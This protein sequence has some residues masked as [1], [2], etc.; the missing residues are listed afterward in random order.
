MPRNVWFACKVT[1]EGYFSRKTH[2]DDSFYEYGIFDTVEEALAP[3]G[4]VSTPQ[5]LILS[6]DEMKYQ[7]EECQIS[8]ALEMNGKLRVTLKNKQIFEST[9][10]NSTESGKNLS[11]QF[12]EKCGYVIFMH[13]DPPNM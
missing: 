11:E 8:Y 13:G 1:V 3:L 7:F 9:A 6:W 2:L 4:P 10:P 5:I 12:H